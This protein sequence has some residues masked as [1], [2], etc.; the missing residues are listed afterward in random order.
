MDF[1]KGTIPIIETDKPATDL[2][3]PSGVSYGY[4]PRDYSQFPQTM[5]ASPSEMNVIPRSEWDARYDE[6]ERT[7]S[8]LEHIY[9]SGPGGSPAF[10]NLDQDGH[11]Y[12][13]AY[14]TGHAIMLDRLRQ[15]L[16]LVRLNPHAAA[17]CI[18]EGRDEGAWSGLS[19]QWARNYGYAV[20]GTGVGEW[21]LHSRDL[22]HETPELLAAMK[23]HRVTEDFV[24]LTQEVWNQNLTEA[25]V[26]TQLFLNNPCPVDFN[27]WGHAVCGVRWVRIEPGDWGILILNS[28]KGWGRHGLGVLRGSKPTP[29]GAV[30]V[31]ASTP[32]VA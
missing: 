15:N 27:H 12:C 14:S 4:V 21:P 19:A 32:S 24:D 30:C 3:R 13:W 17:A 23:L 6:Q 18:K 2:S 16:P 5:F 26:A 22:R 1:Y 20:E 25:Q 28:W 10:V 8:S 9:L 31:R 7:A 29:N 11:G